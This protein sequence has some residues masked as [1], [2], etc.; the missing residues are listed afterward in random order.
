[1]LKKM[2]RRFKYNFKTIVHNKY[3][4]LIAENLVHQYYQD[5]VIPSLLKKNWDFVFLFE[6]GPF[7]S[8]YEPFDQENIDDFWLRVRDS[9]EIRFMLEHKLCPSSSFLEYL[10]K[11]VSIM[12]NRKPDGYLFLLKKVGEI[13]LKNAKTK[14][15]NLIGDIQINCDLKD[16]DFIPIVE[17]EIELIEVKSNKNF[18][19]EEYYKKAILNGYKIRWYNVKTTSF[20]ENDF[21]IEETI[22]QGNLET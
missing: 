7:D 16:I 17:G 11:I 19:K 12:E 20:D 21:L 18:L 22:Y 10:K 15:K 5:D 6:E 8:K 14:Y 3:K 2:E 4:G 1:M 9:C 13:S